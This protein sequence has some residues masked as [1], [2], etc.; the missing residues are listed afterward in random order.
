MTGSSTSGSGVENDTAQ[1]VCHTY[2]SDAFPI[3]PNIATFMS[4]GTNRAIVALVGFSPLFAWKYLPHSM[5]VMSSFLI[6]SATA[7]FGLEFYCCINYP[8]ATAPECGTFG[9]MD[10]VEEMWSQYEHGSSVPDT[11]SFNSKEFPTPLP[12]K[13]DADCSG[14]CTYVKGFRVGYCHKINGNRMCDCTS[15]DGTTT[16]GTASS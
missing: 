3:L 5:K 14:Y 8:G 16:D 2:K 10:L 6:G 12:C 15:S 9:L 1:R 4:S 11:I 13:T 7:L